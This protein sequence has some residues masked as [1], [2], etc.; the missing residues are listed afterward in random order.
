VNVSVAELV[1]YFGPGELLRMPPG[2]L[3]S[4]RL[5]ELSR[6]AFLARDEAERRLYGPAARDPALDGL[7][8]VLGSVPELLA[9]IL[10]PAEAPPP[11]TPEVASGLARSAAGGAHMRLHRAFD[12][13][14]RQGPGPAGASLAAALDQGERE[15]RRLLVR[16]RIAA[17][18]ADA[19]AVDALAATGAD[20]VHG[21]LARACARA[22]RA[23]RSNGARAAELG[24]RA[25]VLARRHA[26]LA[27]ACVL[28][29][30]RLRQPR[31]R[32]TTAS[33]AGRAMQLQRLTLRI[34][35]A[36]R[37]LTPMDLGARLTLI[38]RATRVDWL[39]R[40]LKPY[41][42]VELEG[43]GGRLVVAHRSVVRRGL[44]AGCHV[45]ALGN[46][47]SF[48]DE[49]VLEAEFEGPDQHRTAVWEDW[50]A[51]LARPA[52]DLYPGSLAVEWEFPAIEGR[53]GAPDLLSRW[54]P[55]S[56]A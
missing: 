22:G 21:S 7:L 30:W 1:E 23:S 27:A 9:Q 51:T 4:T 8:G 36:R 50:L 10:P 44:A 49:V 11:Y 54:R 38:G 48:D 12:D 43:A 56:L 53:S 39:E 32:R 42:L 13:G 41:S 5:M 24:L 25:S 26:M 20:A 29:G 6:A 17:E 28:L 15:Y 16:L 55:A 31:L 34:A 35:G 3:T 52:Y 37:A 33:A 19:P 14:V 45:Y 46:V 2:T 18:G 47:K 40:P